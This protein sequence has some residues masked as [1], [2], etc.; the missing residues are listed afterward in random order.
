MGDTRF[1]DGID[2]GDEAGNASTLKRGGTAINVVA[3]PVN[4]GSAS[5]KVFAGTV[6]VGNTGSTAF[7]PSGA[8]TVTFVVASPYGVLPT[9]GT[10]KA[11]T[12]VTAERGSGGTVTIYGYD[13]FGTA[14]DTAG[15]AAYW[16]VGT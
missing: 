5:A 7:V 14:S 12:N 2:L 4:Y 8:T 3:N 15:T 6:I 1:P 16:A 13:Q 11:F 10:A 9:A